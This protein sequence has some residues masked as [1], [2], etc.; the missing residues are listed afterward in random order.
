[1]LG[2]CPA[3]ATGVYLAVRHVRKDA[4]MLFRA[5]TSSTGIARRN[6]AVNLARPS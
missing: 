6:S 3:S 2:G 5:V 4:I 1:M